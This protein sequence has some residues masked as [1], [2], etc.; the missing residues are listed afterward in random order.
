M[1]VDS[2][3]V[4]NLLAQNLA[5]DPAFRAQILERVV[6]LHASIIRDHLREE[7]KA[8]AD[9]TLPGLLGTEGGV[10][11]QVDAR[12]ASYINAK[13]V[14]K[15]IYRVIA[16]QV[17]QTVSIRINRLVATLLRDPDAAGD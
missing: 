10:Y 1:H 6:P 4:A 8:F 2:D 14:E 15:M 13:M 3:Q 5:K 12:V 16:E 7:V 17:G 9:R 11:P